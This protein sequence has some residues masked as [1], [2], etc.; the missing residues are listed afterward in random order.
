MA[1]LAHVCRKPSYTYSLLGS[2]VGVKNPSEDL[3]RRR[4]RE[5]SLATF[6]RKNGRSGRLN[7][8]VD[9]RV[10]GE[11]RR[12]SEAVV[13]SNRSAHNRHQGQSFRSS[14]QIE[15]RRSLSR[16]HAGCRGEPTLRHSDCPA[17]RLPDAVQVPITATR[18]LLVAFLILGFAPFLQ[19]QTDF[20]AAP[21]YFVG[22]LPS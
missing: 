3:S 18:A 11:T 8:R 12:L 5:T 1:L 16:R 19:A 22:Y 21:G 13:S 17:A 9:W 14:N 7:T 6:R 10:S 4:L 15:R 20:S 2:G